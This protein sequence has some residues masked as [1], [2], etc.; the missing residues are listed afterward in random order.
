[1]L[2]RQIEDR[3]AKNFD[4]ADFITGEWIEQ[5][6]GDNQADFYF[7]GPIP[8]M[9]AVN[10]ALKKWGV[11]AERRHYEFFGSFAGLE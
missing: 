11:P 8:F 5:V 1:M 6:V 9:K 10:Q 3:E 7:C 2:P 4:Q